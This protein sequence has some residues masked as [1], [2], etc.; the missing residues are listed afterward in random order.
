MERDIAKFAEDYARQRAIQET[1]SILACYVG[2]DG[3]NNTVWRTT[4]GRDITSGVITDRTRYQAG[5]WVTLERTG[6]GWTVAGLG[7]F[8][9]GDVPDPID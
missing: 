2:L 7:A 1:V 5:Q 9:S 3:D 6:Q 4:D 8:S